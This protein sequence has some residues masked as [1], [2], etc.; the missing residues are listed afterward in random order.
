MEI[1]RRN[2][3]TGRRA[4]RRDVV[5]FGA[6]HVEICHIGMAPLSDSGVFTDLFKDRDE[7]NLRI[8]VP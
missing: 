7:W 5:A 3:Q 6:R 2:G 8:N 1:A 4:F